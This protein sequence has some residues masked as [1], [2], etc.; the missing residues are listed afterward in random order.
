M[1]I[2]NAQVQKIIE[3]ASLENE[4]DMENITQLDISKALVS[5]EQKLNFFGT[6]INF[7]NQKD[8]QNI[9]IVDDLELSIYQLNQLLKKIGVT[10][11]VARNKEEALGELRKKSFNF[12]L[13]DLFLPDSKDGIALIEE[14]VKLRSENQPDL[15]ILIMSGTD[16]K[17]LIDECYRIGADGYIAKSEMWHTEILKYLNSA[18]KRKDNQEFSKS[19]EGKNIISYS[20][21]KLNSKKL[22]DD[23]IVDINSSVLAGYKNVLLNLEQVSTFDPDNAYV[24][25]EIYKICA[26]NSGLFAMVNPSDKIKDALSFAYLDGIIPL[27]YSIESAVKYVESKK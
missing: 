14:A 2:T 10:P 20:V 8:V 18:M 11:S 13:I 1:D 15:N 5:I 7:D 25:A 26:G 3:L 22:F 21:S 9:L 4:L 27:F 24:F 17:S 12:I 6:N 16:D 23:L 19:V